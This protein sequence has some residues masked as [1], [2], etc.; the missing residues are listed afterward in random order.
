M[1]WYDTFQDGR[2]IVKQGDP[3][4]RMYFVISGEVDL[5]RTDELDTGWKLLF[6][7]KTFRILRHYKVTSHI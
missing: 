7:H 3:G 5:K 4:T 2:V 1:I 6:S